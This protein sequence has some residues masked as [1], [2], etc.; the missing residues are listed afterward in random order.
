MKEKLIY[1]APEVE[2]VEIKIGREILTIS[3]GDVSSPTGEG[4]AV[5]EEEW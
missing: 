5:S 4:M 2:Q 1:D 3:N